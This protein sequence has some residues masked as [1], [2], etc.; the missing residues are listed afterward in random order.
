MI[1]GRSKPEVVHFQ[2]L[3]QAL[4]GAA[5]RWSISASGV[6]ASAKLNGEAA[7]R[8][9]LCTSLARVPYRR[10]VGWE[11]RLTNWRCYAES[12]LLFDQNFIYGG[13]WKRSYEMILHP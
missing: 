3:S 1:Y 13:V 8:G 4:I 9:S 5:S 12:S 6:A 10:K 2:S 11:D 7:R